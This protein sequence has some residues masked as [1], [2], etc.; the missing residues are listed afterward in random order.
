MRRAEPNWLIRTLGAGMAFDVLEQEG[1]A[2]AC[3]YLGARRD[4][5]AY[6]LADAVGDFGDLEDGI[7]FR[8]DFFQFAGAFQSSDPGAQVVVGHESSP[9]RE[10]WIIRQPNL[11]RS[12]SGTGEMKCMK[13]TN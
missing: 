3:A 5:R 4:T 2:A 1:G 11:G 13:L 6:I 7:Y 9:S 8:A 10:L 12:K